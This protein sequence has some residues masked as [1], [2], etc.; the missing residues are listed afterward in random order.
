M[1]GSPWHHCTGEYAHPLSL[2][3]SSNS[4]I[5]NTRDCIQVNGGWECAAHDPATPTVDVKRTD[6]D[7]SNDLRTDFTAENRGKSAC[8]HARR[9][10]TMECDL[11]GTLLDKPAIQSLFVEGFCDR[12]D[13][14]Q[15]RGS[16]VDQTIVKSDV[17]MYLYL[18]TR[19][20]DWVSGEQ[21]RNAAQS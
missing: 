15:F 20:P 8:K 12:L 11:K 14:E 16:G 10:G 9:D 2:H 3:Y 21:K 18:A 17:K 5:Q 1:R 6:T 4:I 19:T 7:T 13:G